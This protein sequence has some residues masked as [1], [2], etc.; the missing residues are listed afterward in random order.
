MPKN[1]NK[2][3]KKKKKNVDSASALHQEAAKRPATVSVQW[4]TDITIGARGPGVLAIMHNGMTLASSSSSLSPPQSW[5][6]CGFHAGACGKEDPMLWCGVMEKGLQRPRSD[7]LSSH[8]LVIF[9]DEGVGTM[10]VT[11]WGQSHSRV[12][13]PKSLT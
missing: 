7:S 3:Q 4:R 9:C 5:L 12:P 2:K 6:H 11:G 10:L 13:F 1:K 8:L